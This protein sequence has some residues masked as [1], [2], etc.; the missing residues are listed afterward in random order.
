M[1]RSFFGDAIGCYSRLSRNSLVSK[2]P[3]SS[4]EI[5][6]EKMPKISKS[7]GENTFSLNMASTDYHLSFVSQGVSCK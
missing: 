1:R 4:F 6:S 5:W 2:K 7:T 3:E